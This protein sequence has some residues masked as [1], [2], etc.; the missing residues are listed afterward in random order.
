MKRA[1]LAMAFLVAVPLQ[2]GA[3]QKVPV[4]VMSQIVADCND[5]HA[6]DSQATTSVENCIAEQIESFKKMQK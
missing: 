6:A 3:A 1:I 4:P 2:V 5:E